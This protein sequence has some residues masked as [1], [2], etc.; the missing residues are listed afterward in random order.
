MLK[1]KINCH[2]NILSVLNSLDGS[3]SFIGEKFSH[4]LG[5]MVKNIWHIAL[6]HRSTVKKSELFRDKSYLFRNKGILFSKRV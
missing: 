4:K 5:S 1:F 6:I 2:G 3:E